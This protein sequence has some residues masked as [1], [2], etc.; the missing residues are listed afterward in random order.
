MPDAA[1]KWLED[2]A[3]GAYDKCSMDAAA[4]HIRRLLVENER[5]DVE[6]ERV[7][8]ELQKCHA[9]MSRQGK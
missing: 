6:N 4:G 2:Y 8:G 3:N 7:M 5:L 9:V 1:R